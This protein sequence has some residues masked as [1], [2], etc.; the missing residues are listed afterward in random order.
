ML[1]SPS[2]DDRHAVQVGRLLNAFL[3]TSCKDARAEATALLKRH[4]DL[5][6]ELKGPIATIRRLRRT[7]RTVPR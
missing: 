7:I 4:P 1:P 5:A 6:R 3:D 2:Q